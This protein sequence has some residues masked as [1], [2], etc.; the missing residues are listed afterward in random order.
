[1]TFT[2]RRALPVSSSHRDATDACDDAIELFHGYYGNPIEALDKAIALDPGAV[3]PRVAKAGILLTTSE[4]AFLPLAAA[5]IEAAVQHGAGANARERG[6]I[7]ACRAWLD[8]DW[9]RK[10]SPR[11]ASW[12]ARVSRG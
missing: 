10:K 3:L 11:W 1:M 5:E 2:D 12:S 8:G 4:K 7:A 9:P 6:H